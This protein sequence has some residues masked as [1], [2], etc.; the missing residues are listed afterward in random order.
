MKQLALIGPTASGKTALSIQL[1][2]KLN[3][4]ILSLDSLAIYKQIDIASAKP[5]PNE[6]AGIPHYGIDLLPPDTDFDVMTY[7]TLYHQACEAAKTAEKNLIIVGGTSFYLKILLEGISDLPTLTAE[8]KARTNLALD[9][10]P[11]SYKMLKKIDPLYMN[12]IQATDRYR[13]EKALNIYYQT[14]MPP[15]VYFEAHPPRPVISEPIPL[16]QI[17]IDRAVL[18]ERIALRTQKMLEMGLIDEVA[19]LEKQYGRSPNCM[20]SIGIK[21]TLGFLDGHYNKEMLIEKIIT[22]TARLAKRQVTFNRSQF[23]K[24]YDGSPE[25]L[26]RGISNNRQYPQWALRE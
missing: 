20:K 11:Q 2:Q 3:A 25:T 15:T 24:T 5:T 14:G 1:A 22:N 26:Y 18:R 6:R 8:T 21:E 10:L 7:I 13:I 23:A 17:T 19:Y 4:I 9:S 16:Y 12:K